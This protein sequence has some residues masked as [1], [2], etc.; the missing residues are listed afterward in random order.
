MR[1]GLVREGWCLG[2]C[3]AEVVDDDEIEGEGDGTD[4]VLGAVVCTAS[5]APHLRPLPLPIP[6][7]KGSG[8]GNLPWVW[9]G[10]CVHA[11]PN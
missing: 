11:H 9:V 6:L 7:T 1:E 4:T 8:R 3:D 10:V 2:R 5:L